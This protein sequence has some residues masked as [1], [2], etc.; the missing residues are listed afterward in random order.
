MDISSIVMSPYIYFFCSG[1][2]YDS[3]QISLNWNTYDISATD[4]KLMSSA[5]LSVYFQYH[6]W[7]Q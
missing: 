5:F 3:Q 1:R 4:T 6:V 2:Q 7:D